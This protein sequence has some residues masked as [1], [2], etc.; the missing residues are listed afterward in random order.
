[1]KMRSKENQAKWELLQEDEKRKSAVEER[2][3]IAHEKCAMVESI[4]EENKTMLMDPSIMN[5]Y[6]RE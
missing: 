5:N 1:M 2:R 6:I 4:A 3:A